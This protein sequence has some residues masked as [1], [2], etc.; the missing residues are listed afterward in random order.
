[1]NDQE[2]IRKAVQEVAEEH[3]LEKVGKLLGAAL[4]YGGKIA[5]KITPF[6]GTASKIKEGFKGTAPTGKAAPGTTKTTYGSPRMQAKHGPVQPSTAQKVGQT[7][8]S[9]TQIP[10]KVGTAL[11]TAPA[12]IKNIPA[13]I[14]ANPAK[15]AKVVTGTA[16]AGGAIVG[17]IAAKDALSSPTSK[18]P[19][20]SS[21]SSSSPGGGGP[22]SGPGGAK[23]ITQ[24]QS[25][26][27]FMGRTGKSG[28]AKQMVQGYNP[29]NPIKMLKEFVDNSTSPQMAQSMPATAAEMPMA[30][31]NDTYQEL[32]GSN[33]PPVKLKVDNQDPDVEKVTEAVM[34]A[35]NPFM[36]DKKRKRQEAVRQDI[37][38]QLQV[39]RDHMA[40]TTPW[41]RH[42]QTMAE[43]GWSGEQAR[44]NPPNLDDP[45][46][47]RKGV[48]RPEGWRKV[49]PSLDPN[50][51]GKDSGFNR[52][53]KQQDVEKITEA[54]MK[55]QEDQWQSAQQIGAQVIDAMM[56]NPS[57]IPGAG[58]A[59]GLYDKMRGKVSP[60]AIKD[61]KF[62]E[63]G[64]PIHPKTGKPMG[65]KQ[66]TQFYGDVM[67][68]KHAGTQ[69]FGQQVMNQPPQNIPPKRGPNEKPA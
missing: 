46:T 28:H 51:W 7:A 37:E 23:P 24:Q 32:M 33:L 63:S 54:V 27:R 8:Q 34:K 20:S 50:R 1:M 65:E 61:M 67:G 19:G 57:M 69:G 22:V 38:R 36:S 10:G 18:P 59:K 29:N 66:M 12:K 43:G 58:K 40:N 3:D 62:D 64:M 15:T 13:A 2:L 47:H 11:H 25:S 21:S 14:A 35:W 52:I 17:G 49:A 42:E 4:K 41:E 9:A 6:K 55:Q 30:V 26:S 60:D 53:E 68:S 31:L 16:A 56:Y 5:S 48:E 45:A 39:H 44:L